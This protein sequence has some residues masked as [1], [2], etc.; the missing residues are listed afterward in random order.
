MLLLFEFVVVD[1]FAPGNFLIV[2]ELSFLLMGSGA[3]NPP[4]NDE[5]GL[6]I[7]KNDDLGA[8]VVDS[9]SS[10][11]LFALFEEKSL[12]EVEPEIN[13]RQDEFRSMILSRDFILSKTQKQ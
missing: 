5:N 9:M 3:E 11:A 6:F 4:P 13:K 2:N 8:D 1:V 7:I 10:S 12:I